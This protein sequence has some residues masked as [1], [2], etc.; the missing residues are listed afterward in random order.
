[1]MTMAQVRTLTVIRLLNYQKVRGPSCSKANQ[2]LEPVLVRKLS[3]STTL[4]VFIQSKLLRSLKLLKISK[5]FPI[6]FQLVCNNRI[7]ARL[8]KSFMFSALNKEE[9]DIVVGAMVERNFRAGENVI[10]QGD[11]GAVLFVVEEG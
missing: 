3:E 1:M 7:K 4:K 6:C 11:A 8:S 5:F 10:R 9:Q 2:R